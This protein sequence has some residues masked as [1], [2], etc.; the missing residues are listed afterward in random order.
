KQFVTKGL[1]RQRKRL[2]V[3][4]PSIWITQGLSRHTWLRIPL[5]RQ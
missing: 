1:G 5:S 4:K 3:E 2:P